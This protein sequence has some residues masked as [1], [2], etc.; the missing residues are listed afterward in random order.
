ME[1]KKKTSTAISSQ[2]GKIQTAKL[3]EEFLRLVSSVFL[4]LLKCNKN[5]EEEF[6][7]RK[8]D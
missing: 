1:V 3:W 4:L 7:E 6:Q 5:E 8:L 2:L